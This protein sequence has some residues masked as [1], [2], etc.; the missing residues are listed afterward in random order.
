[1]DD[2]VAF[3]ADRP[4]RGGKKKTYDCL[5]AKFGDERN[6]GGKHSYRWNGNVRQSS[7]IIADYDGEQVSIVDAAKLLEATA[8]AGVHLLVAASHCTPEK[9]RWRASIFTVRRH[10]S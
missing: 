6:P 1:M 7:G 3:L 2:L 5:L 8:V 4:L 10:A 9:P